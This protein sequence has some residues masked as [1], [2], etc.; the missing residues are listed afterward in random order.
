MTGDSGSLAFVYFRLIFQWHMIPEMNCFMVKNFHF[1]DQEY[2]AFRLA[3]EG[4][5]DAIA[6]GAEA[7]VY[8]AE[9]SD[10]LLGRI[11]PVSAEQKT[12]TRTSTKAVKP[13]QRPPTV[14]KLVSRKEEI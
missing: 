7:P 10:Y 6:M 2:F 9:A 3:F 5:G 8:E 1:E 14:K 4:S 12:Q 11:F 13:D